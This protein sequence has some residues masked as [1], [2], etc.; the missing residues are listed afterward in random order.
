MEQHDYAVRWAVANRE[1]IAA[2]FCERLGVNRKAL[3]D[4]SHNTVTAV[5]KLS[6]DALGFSQN[7]ENTGIFENLL[8]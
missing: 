8:M 5:D 7:M 3:L 4:V 2:R 6:L 1:V